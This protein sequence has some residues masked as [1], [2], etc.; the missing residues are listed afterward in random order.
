MRRKKAGLTDDT[1]EACLTDATMAQSLVAWFEENR[2]ADNIN[3]TPS[4]VIDGDL[5][6]NMSY[7]EFQNILDAKVN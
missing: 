5:Y 4:F 6:R 2:A 3:S 7:S 1:L